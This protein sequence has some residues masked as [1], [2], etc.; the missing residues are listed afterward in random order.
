MAVGTTCQPYWSPLFT[1][2][3]GPYHIERELGSGGM[4]SEFLAHD[5]RHERDV[6][7]KVL[8]SDVGYATLHRTKLKRPATQPVESPYR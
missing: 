8:K 7:I 2:L 3:A 1:T 5:L 4:A 6:A